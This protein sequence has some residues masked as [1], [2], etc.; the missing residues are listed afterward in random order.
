MA[1]VKLEHRNLRI[2]KKTGQYIVENW[3]DVIACVSQLLLR[4]QVRASELEACIRT[5]QRLRDSGEPFPGSEII[6]DIVE[7]KS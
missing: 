2:N 1:K 3:N 4:V 5:F 6:E 7:K